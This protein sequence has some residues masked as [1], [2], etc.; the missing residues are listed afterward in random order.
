M[1]TEMNG[2]LARRKQSKTNLRFIQVWVATK[3]GSKASLDPLWMRLRR[4]A[5][6]R[7]PVSFPLTAFLKIANKFWLL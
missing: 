3:D 2:I 4:R 5:G 7:L 1:T 6:Y